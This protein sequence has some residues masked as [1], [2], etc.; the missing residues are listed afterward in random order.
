MSQFRIAAPFALA[1]AAAVLAVPVSGGAAEIVR[2][3]A[4]AFGDW[5][6]DA[7]GVWRKITASDLPSVDPNSPRNNAR[8]VAAPA[9]AMPKALPG[10]EVT[11][12]AKLE[13]P[14]QI[15]LAPNG[16]LFIT[17]SLKGQIRVLRAKPGAKTP[18]T[19]ELFITGLDRPFGMAFYP[20]A[21]PK[22]LYVANTNSIVR[23]PYRSGDLKASGPPQVLIPTL[24][25]GDIVALDNL[26][27][28]KIAAVRAAIEAKG[29]QL[30]LL[31]P[32]AFA[33]AGS[34]RSRRAGWRE[35]TSTRLS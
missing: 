5:H 25:P 15:K 11:A 30:F 9:G 2:Q 20:A 13:G 28:H 6:G 4:E 3:G 32:P 22:W 19:T 31:P 21:N 35:H 7:P 14:R 18:E 17:E 26:P 34:E 23:I 24:K 33:G 12:F 10:F 8:V 16:D 1:V 29:A 27:A